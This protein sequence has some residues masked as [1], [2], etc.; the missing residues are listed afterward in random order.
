MV[1]YYSYCQHD[2]GL[3]PAGG[4]WGYNCNS[5]YNDNSVSQWA[6][7]GLIPAERNFGARHRPLGSLLE[8]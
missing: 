5:D 8:R 6:A 4:G 3:Y 1:D 7:I 2:L